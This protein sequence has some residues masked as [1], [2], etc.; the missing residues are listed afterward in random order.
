MKIRTLTKTEVEEVYKTMEQK[1][2][3]LTG[4]EGEEAEHI[5]GI[6]IIGF[7]DDNTFSLSNIGQIR[8]SK[9]LDAISQA[10]SIYITEAQ[11]EKQKHA[12]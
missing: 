12:E 4:T 7:R 9:L 8:L 6:L 10:I 11:E 3:E 5:E 2:T 1:I